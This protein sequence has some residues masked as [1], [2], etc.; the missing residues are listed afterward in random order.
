MGN[1]LLVID[2]EIDICETIA[3]IAR[4]RGFEVETLSNPEEVEP[5]L[6]R[7][8]PDAVML[9]LMMPGVDGVELLRV[10]STRVKQV[11]VALMSGSDARVLNGARRLGAAHGLDVLA[12]LE[13]PLDIKALR[14]TLDQMK[15]GAPP[16][17][18]ADLAE[19]ISTGQIALHYQPMVE[20]ASGHLAAVEALARWQHPTRGLLSP[21][22]SFEQAARENLLES[23]SAHMLALAAKQLAALKAAGRNVPVSVNLDPRSVL[24]PGL[25]ERIAELRRAHDLPPGSLVIEV[26]ESDALKDVAK[27]AD[28]LTRLKERGAEIWLDAFAG[29][30]TSLRDLLRLPAS[31]LKIDRAA[32]L[33]ITQGAEQEQW[34]AM[35]VA[36]AKTLGLRVAAVGVET[37]EMLGLVKKLGCTHAQGFLIARPMGGDELLAFQ[38]P[39]L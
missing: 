34:V 20:L 38:P 22:E 29:G 17:A 30:A 21:A 11:R 1:R 35:A 2:D 27:M 24:D 9:D 8:V 15:A 18:K 10:L 32:V 14:A 4:D 23:L 6:T 37:T 36:L 25:P 28:A 33:S 13:K 19:A 7:F 3:E 31:L 12:A 26:Q 39:K 16:Q 5:V